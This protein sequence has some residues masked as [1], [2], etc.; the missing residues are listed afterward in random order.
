LHPAFRDKNGNEI[1]GIFD[2]AY[3]GCIYDVSAS[4][5]ITDDS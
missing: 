1:D 4:S 3:E 5:Y 2:S